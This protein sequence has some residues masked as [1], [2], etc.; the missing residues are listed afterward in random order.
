MKLTAI[1]KSGLLLLCTFF[2]LGPVLAQKVIERNAVYKPGQEIILELPI[3]KTILISGWDK[4]EVAL[5]ATVNINN[6]KLNEAYALEV[7]NGEVLYMEASLDEEILGNGTVADCDNNYSFQRISNGKKGAVCAE[8]YYEIKVPR[9]AHLRLETISA[10][11]EAMGLEGPTQLK[12]I[13]GFIDFSWP[14]QEGADLQ[15]KSIT[16][17]LYT[18]LAFDILNKKKEAPMVGYELKGR[19]GRGGP[20]LEL[21]TISNNIYLRGSK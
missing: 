15:L 8:I 4:E 21:E 9:T 20:L 17:E 7:N 2:L 18:D 3:G 10:D 1:I 16:G 14:Q 11:V 6:N 12:S 13:S 19:K 5:K